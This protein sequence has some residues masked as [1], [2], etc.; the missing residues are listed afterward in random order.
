MVTMADQRRDDEEPETTQ[1]RST[2]LLALLACGTSTDYCTVTLLCLAAGFD[3]QCGRESWRGGAEAAETAG[4]T[5]VASKVQGERGLGSMLMSMLPPPSSLL[6][7]LSFL[8][9]TLLGSVFFQSSSVPPPCVPL[10]RHT[11]SF[12]PSHLSSPLIPPLPPLLPL[13]SSL[14]TQFQ[15]QFN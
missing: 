7:P 4:L 3:D 11:H 15:F 14:L 10:A 12:L 8:N 13:L 5:G 9:L 1:S 6:A 2:A